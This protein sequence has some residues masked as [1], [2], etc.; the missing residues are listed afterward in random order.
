MRILLVH[1]RYLQP[2]GEDV[3]FEAE[4]RLLRRMGHQVVVW[5]DH[6]RRL[7]AMPPWRAAMTAIWSREAVARLRALIRSHRPQVVHVHNTFPVLSPA[8]YTAAREAGIPVV[9]TLH[10]YRLLC[11]AGVLMRQGRVCEACLGK[12]VPWPGVLHGCWRGSRLQTAVAAAMLSFHHLRGTWQTDVDVYIA[13]TEFARRK[14]I[15]GGLP[16]EKVAV[17][18]NF[19]D[20]DPGP[21][22]HEGGFALFVGRL[23]AEKGLP[24]LLAGWTRLPHIPLRIVG[25]GPLRPWL[26]ARLQ[27]PRLQHV[28]L[29]GPMSRE[30]VLRLMQEAR[31]LVF[32]S[33]WYEGFPMVLVEALATGL[34]V[35]ASDLG[36]MPEILGEA[37][38]LFP[39]GQPEALAERVAWL[40]ARPGVQREMQGQARARY[41]AHYTAQPNYE[42]LMALYH[43]TT[44]DKRR[45]TNDQRRTTNNKRPT[46]KKG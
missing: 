30:E 21:G 19:L 13:L 2:G 25:D 12:R 32:P 43:R 18:P 44:N 9:Q 36:A 7:L 23:A 16:A 22:R 39:P 35:V 41:L 1:A 17:K 5:V 38:L 11:P 46:T 26:Q 28:R 24:T 27:D 33:T 34:P 6:N 37:G 3:A 42:R 40:W 15:Q 45:T 4:S 14:F 29:L 10:N 20:P 8:V 31:M